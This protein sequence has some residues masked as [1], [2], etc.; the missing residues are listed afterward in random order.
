MLSFEKNRLVFVVF[1]LCCWFLG[2][3]ANISSEKGVKNEEIPESSPEPVGE[4]TQADNLEP[5]PE[6]EPEPE[7]EHGGHMTDKMF[8]AINFEL[9][10][11]LFC[12]V[13]SPEPGNR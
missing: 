6:P 11:K 4:A 8:P 10:L 7:G 9:I 13:F 5:T 12:G 3:I 2:A 1:A